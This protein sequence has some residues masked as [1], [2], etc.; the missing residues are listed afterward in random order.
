[1]ALFYSLCLC[2]NGVYLTVH[3][4]YKAVTRFVRGFNGPSCYRENARIID[5]ER[6]TQIEQLSRLPQNQGR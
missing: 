6:F 3:H 4:Q 2:N 1:M 5:N